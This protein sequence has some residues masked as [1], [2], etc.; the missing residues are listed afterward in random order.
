MAWRS[1]PLGRSSDRPA[2]GSGVRLGLDGVRSAGSL[3][4]RGVLESAVR[5]AA[6]ARAG[7]ARPGAAVSESAG[8]PPAP[9]LDRAPG[10]SDGRCGSRRDLSS[11]GSRF[12]AGARSPRVRAASG[13]RDAASVPAA[14]FFRGRGTVG[15]RSEAPRRG[16]GGELIRSLPTPGAAPRSRPDRPPDPRVELVIRSTRPPNRRAHRRTRIRI[17]RPLRPTPRTLW[18]RAAPRRRCLRGVGRRRK[19]GERPWRW[20]MLSVSGTSAHLDAPVLIDSVAP[21]GPPSSRPTR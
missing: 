12:W 16:G 9:R 21:H 17:L 11:A 3:R 2:R 19:A 14:V 1:R 6:P 18:N 13:R 20:A 8:R 7:A 4:R 10:D 5:F 15:S